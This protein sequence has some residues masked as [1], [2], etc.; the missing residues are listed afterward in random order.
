MTLGAAWPSPSLSAQ[1]Q[2]VWT[3]AL[4]NTDRVAGAR[5]LREFLLE[6]RSDQP[7]VGE[8]VRR[9]LE[10]ELE[11]QDGTG[12]LSPEDCADYVLGLVGPL[13]RYRWCEAFPDDHVGVRD[14]FATVAWCNRLCNAEESDLPTLAAQVREAWR[15]RRRELLRRMIA[16]RNGVPQVSTTPNPQL[17]G[18]R[19]ALPNGTGRPIGLGELFR[20]RETEIRQ[21][22]NTNRANAS[23]EIEVECNASAA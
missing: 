15:A 22:A 19:P 20:Q 8:I 18:P 9:A 23:E 5:A 7:H 12:L 2:D 10:I 3:S 14:C 11:T 16:E 6:G 17:E 1:T 4:L 13:G 21:P